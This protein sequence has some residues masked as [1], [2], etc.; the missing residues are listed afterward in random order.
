M[1]CVCEKHPTSAL[2][3]LSCGHTLGS[4]TGD[5]TAGWFGWS[6]MGD[7]TYLAESHNTMQQQGR[8]KVTSPCTATHRQMRELWGLRAFAVV[9]NWHLINRATVA[10]LT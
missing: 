3:Q 1:P 7:R 10:T 6:L 9:D 4:V 2:K 8:N 5:L